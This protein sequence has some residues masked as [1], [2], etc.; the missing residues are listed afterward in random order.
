MP[1]YYISDIK[2]SDPATVTFAASTY[3]WL[4]YYGSALP[5]I[6]FHILRISS[7]RELLLKIQ[8]FR[9]MMPVYW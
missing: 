7:F 6:E 3:F 8:A 4:P 1:I 2:P 5:R 9:D